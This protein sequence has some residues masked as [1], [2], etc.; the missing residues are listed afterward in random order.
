MA[1]HRLPCLPARVILKQLKKKKNKTCC[2]NRTLSLAGKNHTYAYKHR[3]GKQFQGY[4]KSSKDPVAT[5]SRILKE[6]VLSLFS[7]LTD[8][9]R[10]SLLTKLESD[11]SE[12]CFWP[13][14]NL[15]LCPWIVQS[16][17]SRNPAGSV[18][19]KSPPPGYL[20]KF[21]I[22]HPGYLITL[23]SLQQKS[24]WVGLARIPPVLIFPPSTFPPRDP[25]LLL[26]YASLPALVVFRVE[27]P[28]SPF[29][30]NPH[31]SSLFWVKSS[32]TIFNKRHE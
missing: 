4:L 2:E 6:I 22:L 28:L 3:F 8:T 21:L 32:W 11:C 23:A 16:S 30:Q 13:G 18:L 20:I 14:P 31:C 9:Q 7:L 27:S 10:L 17:F 24:C 29:L 12:S 1:L 5:N 19:Q 15:G 25:T 26:G